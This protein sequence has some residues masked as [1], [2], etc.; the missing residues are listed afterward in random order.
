MEKEWGGVGSFWGKEEGQNRG[1]YFLLEKKKNE[2]HKGSPKENKEKTVRKNAKEL[3][4]QGTEQNTAFILSSWHVH[5]WPAPQ[6]TREK[7]T[8]MLEASSPEFCKA[9]SLC[10]HKTHVWYCPETTATI[11][12]FFII[13]NCGCN[14]YATC[15]PGSIKSVVILHTEHKPKD[16]GDSETEWRVM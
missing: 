7:H 9:G 3:R 1:F 4:K 14:K 8:K 11:N 13:R 10:R 2:E 6:S 15:L 5:K 12:S 16:K